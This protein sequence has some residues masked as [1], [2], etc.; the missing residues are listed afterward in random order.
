VVFDPLA[1]LLL[2][3]ANMSMRKPEPPKPVVKETIVTE[4]MDI[5]VFV[6]KDNS[7]HVER[8]NLANIV[9]DEASG[10]SIPPISG[11]KKLQPKYDYSEPFS[12]K[13]NK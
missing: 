5:P 4:E 13:E 9:I 2:I 12:F 8:D 3:A 7:I 1:V 10:E 6:P 11:T